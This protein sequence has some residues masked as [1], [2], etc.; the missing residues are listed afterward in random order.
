MP[1]N[2]AQC[3]QPGF[4]PRLLNLES[5]ALTM[6]PPHPLI[7]CHSGMAHNFGPRI[8]SAKFKLWLRQISLIQ[9]LARSLCF[10]L[11]QVHLQFQQKLLIDSKLAQKETC[12]KTQLQGVIS[13]RM[14]RICKILNG[15]KHKE[16]SHQSIM[17]RDLGPRTLWV[18]PGPPFYRFFRGF[19]LLLALKSCLKH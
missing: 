3:P 16:K 5:S 6:R 9:V 17:G 10:V 7:L 8:E 18:Y 11:R 1:K 14:V 4:K 19:T 15:L 13:L 2:T 12:V